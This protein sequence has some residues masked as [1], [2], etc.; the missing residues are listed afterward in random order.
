[1]PLTAQIMPKKK[2]MTRTL[3]E[4]PFYTP[5][6]PVHNSSY[7]NNLG[8]LTPAP[9]PTPPRTL[10]PPAQGN[11][12]IP[13]NNKSLFSLYRPQTTTRP[14]L[15]KPQWTTQ[16]PTIKTERHLPNSA[17]NLKLSNQRSNII[18]TKQGFY[19]LRQFAKKSLDKKLE[20]GNF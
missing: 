9:S 13:R 10:P 1:M 12:Q 2:P 8:M 19:T 18:T 14:F 16:K 15:S 11:L 7:K 6:K 5:P 20:N 4:N 17:F 3:S